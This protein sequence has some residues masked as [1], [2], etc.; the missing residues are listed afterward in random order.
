MNGSVKHQAELM[1]KASSG[2][3]QA[4]IAGFGEQLLHGFYVPA[5]TAFEC[6]TGVG[7]GAA[8]EAAEPA[9]LSSQLSQ[10]VMSSARQRFRWP[11]VL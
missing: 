2:T 4:P 9:Q 5:D 7:A 10:A 8:E 11:D 6:A 1:R 3:A